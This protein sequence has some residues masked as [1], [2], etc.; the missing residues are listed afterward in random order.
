MCVCIYIM[1]IFDN[2]TT[3]TEQK[4]FTKIGILGTQLNQFIYIHVQFKNWFILHIQS[5]CLIRANQAQFV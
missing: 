2:K 5:Q 3:E 4:V 1:Y